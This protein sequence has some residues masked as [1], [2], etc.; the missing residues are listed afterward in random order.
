MVAGQLQEEIAEIHRST[1]PFKAAYA[2][3]KAMAKG[4]LSRGVK[5]VEAAQ[6]TA[7]AEKALTRET[8]AA[9]VEIQARTRKQTLH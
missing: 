4:A 3:L 2:D 8:K 6:K 5:A 9:S 1:K 7:A